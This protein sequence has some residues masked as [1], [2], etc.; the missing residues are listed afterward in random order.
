[1]SERRVRSRDEKKR[2]RRNVQ[3]RDRGPC[4][5]VSG[6]ILFVYTLQTLLFFILCNQNRLRCFM[7]WMLLASR[8]FIRSNGSCQSIMGSSRDERWR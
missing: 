3:G 4:G 1:M 2:M 5:L 8:S 7:M 6:S